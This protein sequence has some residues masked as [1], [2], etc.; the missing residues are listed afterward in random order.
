VDHHTQFLVGFVW[1][2]THN[3]TGCD[4]LHEPH[5]QLGVMIYTNPTKNWCDILHK[6]HQELGV[7]IYTNSTKLGV[8]IYTNPTT[9]WV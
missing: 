1:I 5:L 6:P 3:L 9:N 7:T 8:M 4:D 2:I